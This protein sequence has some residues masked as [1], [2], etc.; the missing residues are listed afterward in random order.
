[1]LF[2]RTPGIKEIP[3][4]IADHCRHFFCYCIDKYNI[5]SITR[6]D[7]WIGLTIKSYLFAIRAPGKTSNIKIPFRNGFATGNEMQSELLFVLLV[8]F[9]V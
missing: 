4:R 6:I 1:M 5:G 8:S 7:Q 9:D 2:H 3:N